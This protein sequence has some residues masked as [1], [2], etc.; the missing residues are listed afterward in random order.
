MKHAT[1]LMKCKAVPDMTA[2]FTRM[3]HLAL[4]GQ[5]YGA[6]GEAGPAVY[7]LRSLLPEDL[8]A[9]CVQ[10]PREAK[11]N[12]ALLMVLLQLIRHSG[13][14]LLEGEGCN[15]CAT[16]QAEPSNQAGRVVHRVKQDTSNDH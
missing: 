13:D 10:P 12:H 11:L 2:D 8:R 9:V 15:L 3:Q 14:H 1:F 6:A 4:T 5:L 7:V 16:I